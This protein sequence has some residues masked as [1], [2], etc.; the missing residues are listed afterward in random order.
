MGA[1]RGTRLFA[2]STWARVVWG[3]VSHNHRAFGL[4]RLQGFVS[5]HDFFEGKYVANTV[6]TRLD[7]GPSRNFNTGANL[8]RVSPG[9]AYKSKN[10]GGFRYTC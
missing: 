3:D 7:D 4:S 5:Q 2:I 1:R 9:V 10:K 8:A 6:R